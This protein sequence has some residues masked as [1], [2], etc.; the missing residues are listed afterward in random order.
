MK[1][2]IIAGITATMTVAGNAVTL[3]HA[4]ETTPTVD[5]PVQDYV[6]TRLEDIVQQDAFK[7]ATQ[8]DQEQ[9]TATQK[10]TDSTSALDKAKKDVLE[11]K[12]KQTQA[13]SALTAEDQKAV[14]NIK[15][16]EQDAQD[17]LND[18]TKQSAALEVLKAEAKSA[19]DAAIQAESNKKSAQDALDKAQ[20]AA[21]SNEEF[22]KAQAGAKAKE[23]AVTNAQTAYDQANDAVKKASTTLDEATKSQKTATDDYNKAKDAYTQAE[24]KLIR[25]NKALKDAQ[26]KAA[27]YA[28]KD[29]LQDAVSKAQTDVDKANADQKT[30]E[31]NL[32]AKKDAQTKANKA[33][34]DANAALTDAQTAL[35]TAQNQE[36]EAKTALENAKKEQTVAQTALD[37]ANKDK[38][39]AEAQLNQ[40][41][42]TYDDALKANADASEAN[43]QAQDLIDEQQKIVDDL[44]VKADNAQAQYEKGFKGFLEDIKGKTT[45]QSML[46]T[47]NRA[48]EML[49]GTVG[50][51]T[52]NGKEI[53]EYLAQYDSTHTAQNLENALASIAGMEH[54]NELR[55]KEGLST[56]N[57][58]YAIIAESMVKSDVAAAIG[59]HPDYDVYSNA[60]NLEK[61]SPTSPKAVDHL[62]SEKEIFDQLV[63]KDSE[64]ENYRYDAYAFFKKYPKDFSNVGHYLNIVNKKSKYFAMSLSIVE[65][66]KYTTNNKWEQAFGYS[67]Q[68][69]N[70]MELYNISIADYKQQLQSYVNDL[71]FTI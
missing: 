61:G 17:A 20:K 50:S 24:D 60:E 15:Q 4:E 14:T 45:D 9:Q 28:S 56:L 71:E 65:D 8:A 63:E 5:T 19:E 12:D 6:D 7:K 36:K 37:N 64:V 16:K 55:V 11:A 13:S 31:N 44:K 27:Q 69:S 1:K 38:T 47:I 22:A 32:A 41:Q 53:T 67:T 40:A 42:K 62:Y 23:T 58:N 49:A 48:L 68:L 59:T 25:A 29:A 21:A 57:T 34:D 2:Q 66:Y 26:D 30:A 33:L 54:T 10:V 18:Y 35:T 39:A 46:D 70:G 43:K 51:T 3:V 52:V